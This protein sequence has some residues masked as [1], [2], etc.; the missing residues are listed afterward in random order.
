M[1]FDSYS[2]FLSLTIVGEVAFIAKLN[3]SQAWFLQV[4]LG[5]DQL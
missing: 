3:F 4:T 1:R 2:D 5:F